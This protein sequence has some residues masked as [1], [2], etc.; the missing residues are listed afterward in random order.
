MST[1]P[2]KPKTKRRGLPKTRS[3][4]RTCKKRRVKCGEEKP[5]CVRCINFGVQCDGYG[6]E[7]P[8]FEGKAWPIGTAQRRPLLLPKGASSLPLARSPSESLFCAEKDHHYFEVFCTKTCFQILPFFDA[9]VFRQMLLQASV[10]E[11]SLRHAVVA[12]AAMDM[13]MQ[14]LDD[15]ESLS[16][17]DQDK[18]SH[19][20]HM[21]A[22]NEYSV[23]ISK[24]RVSNIPPPTATQCT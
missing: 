24:M 1:I 20:H 9:G 7:G 2:M 6:R 10:S 19:L 13:K 11:D 17:S 3:G 21:N 5:E 23:A 15:F 12:L 4:C 8:N 18:S 16:L 14:T 22:L